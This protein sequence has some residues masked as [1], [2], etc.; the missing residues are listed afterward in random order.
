MLT[1]SSTLR[2]FSRIA[3]ASVALWTASCASTPAGPDIKPGTAFATPQAAVDATV[4][5]IRAD[6]TEE[7]SSILGVN[8]REVLSSG[9]DV[10][11]RSNAQ[12]F[13]RKYDQS[14]RLV[15]SDDGSMILEVGDDNWPMP[16]P[17]VKTDDGW[18]LDTAAGLEEVIARRVGRNELDCIQTCLAIADAQSDYQMMDPDGQ[19]PPA[20]ASKF[21]SDPGTKNGLYWPVSEGGSPSPLGDLAASA[22]AEGYTASEDGEP[23]PYHGYFFRILTAQGPFA[24]GGRMSYLEDGRLVHG[25]AVVAYPAEYG[26]SGIMTFMIAKQG[27]VYQRDLGPNTAAVA[28]SMTEFNP[29]QTWTEAN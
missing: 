14:H 7:L 27:V 9:D 4:A 11:D 16:F 24:P 10:A 18:R 15:A 13:L 17:I 21:M 1:A 12:A 3:L 23:R 25:F 28:R 22:S 2:V 6:N 26:R 5:A 29:D 8:A 19:M 20:F